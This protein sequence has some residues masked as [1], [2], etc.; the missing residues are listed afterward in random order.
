MVTYS[1][2]QLKDTQYK[3]NR[4]KQ[5]GKGQE[6]LH[7]GKSMHVCSNHFQAVSQG[8]EE[9]KQILQKKEKC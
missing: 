2:F 4:K 3:N 7:I 6:G 1:I 8:K 9:C 5:V